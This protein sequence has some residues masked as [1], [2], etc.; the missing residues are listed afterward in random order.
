MYD[1]V[2]YSWLVGCLMYVRSFVEHT[3]SKIFTDYTGTH[4]RHHTVDAPGILFILFDSQ[5]S[6]VPLDLQYVCC[7]WVIF[8]QLQNSSCFQ[9]KTQVVVF[10]SLLKLVFRKRSLVTLYVDFLY[11]LKISELF[12]LTYFFLLCIPRYY[13]HSLLLFSN[14]WL[15]FTC[16]F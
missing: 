12:L 9:M 13:T 6:Y 1:G 2:T 3:T 10:Q 11:L 4:D 7:V 16:C 14:V 5:H 8:N 15:T